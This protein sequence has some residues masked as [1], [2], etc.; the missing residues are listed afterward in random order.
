MTVVFFSKEDVESRFIPPGKVTELETV[1]H[2]LGTNNLV[3]VCVMYNEP[4][5][6]PRGRAHAASSLGR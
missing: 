5:L 1:D 6:T 2:V 3:C 4:T